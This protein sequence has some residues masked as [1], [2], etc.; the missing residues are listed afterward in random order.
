M[1][2]EADFENWTEQQLRPYLDT[3]LTAFG[4]DRLMFGSTA[5]L[6]RRFCL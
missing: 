6:P 4:P 1:V 3:V 2:T 5:C